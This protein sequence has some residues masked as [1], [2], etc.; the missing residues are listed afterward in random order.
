MV[1]LNPTPFPDLERLLLE[2]EPGVELD[3]ALSACDHRHQQ[4]VRHA[5]VLTTKLV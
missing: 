3:L 2:Q 1:V 4:V 5:V